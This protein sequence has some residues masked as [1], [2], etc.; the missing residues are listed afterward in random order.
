MPREV[1]QPKVGRSHA[2]IRVGGHVHCIRGADDLSPIQIERLVLLSNEKDKLAEEGTID[3]A[4]S[5]M[6][7]LMDLI[8][9][10]ESLDSELEALMVGDHLH[11]GP[12]DEVLRGS[13]FFALVGW[14]DFFGQRANLQGQENLGRARKNLGRAARRSTGTKSPATS[15]RTTAAAAASRTG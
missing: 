5:N 14:F 9:I 1:Y 15:K 13:P 6:Y 7:E 3:E 11:D 10:R 4:F 12:S 2:G 8:F